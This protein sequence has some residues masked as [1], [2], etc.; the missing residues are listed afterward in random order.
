MPLLGGFEVGIHV[1]NGAKQVSTQPQRQNPWH[2]QVTCQAVTRPL[3][4][5]R[6][7]GLGFRFRVYGLGVGS[8]IGL[9]FW[10]LGFRLQS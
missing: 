5:F 1:P 10:G 3:I 4:Q 7:Q 6:V 8:N 9:R 2:V